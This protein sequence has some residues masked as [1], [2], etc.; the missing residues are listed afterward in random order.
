MGI[1]R[2]LGFPALN[3]GELT[4]SGYIYPKFAKIKNN[5]EDEIR[6][7]L[8]ARLM[9]ISFTYKMIT[10]S[11]AVTAGNLGGSGGI[12]SSPLGG[13]ALGL[14]GGA[15][16]SSLN[17]GGIGQGFAYL[18]YH[19]CEGEMRRNIPIVLTEKM[20]TDLKVTLPN[21]VVSVLAVTKK[22]I[23]FTDEQI[24]RLSDNPG[25]NSIHG[26]DGLTYDDGQFFGRS[27]T[28]F[29]DVGG[30]AFTDNDNLFDGILFDDRLLR[31]RADNNQTSN[32]GFI[33]TS[34]RDAS[35]K[36]IKLNVGNI[37]QSKI[38]AGDTVY[39]TAQLIK[40]RIE[41]VCIKHQATLVET[42]SPLGLSGS[43]ILNT[44]NILQSWSSHISKFKVPKSV[45]INVEK[46]STYRVPLNISDDDTDKYDLVEGWRIASSS[47][48]R[49]KVIFAADRR[50]ILKLTL[51][52]GGAIF[53]TEV[54]L[55]RS[56]IRD[57]EWFDQFL[58]DNSLDELI[59]STD[60][61]K[62]KLER[63][64]SHGA[65]FDMSA[66]VNQV[67][68]DKHKIPYWRPFALA[69]QNVSPFKADDPTSG[70]GITNLD[71]LNDPYNTGHAVADS[72]KYDLSSVKFQFVIKNSNIASTDF[73]NIGAWGVQ[74]CGDLEGG[75]GFYDPSDFLNRTENRL[76]ITGPPTT[77]GNIVSI[78][79]IDTPFYL[80]KFKRKTRIYVENFTVGISPRSRGG[81][82]VYVYTLPLT[83]SSLSADISPFA[84]EAVLTFNDFDKAALAMHHFQ[85]GY[86]DLEQINTETNVD[87]K[88]PETFDY[89]NSLYVGDNR[90]IGDEPGYS[91]GR[92]IT[93]EATLSKLEQLPKDF[94]IT[95]DFFNSIISE[96][97]FSYIRTD[98]T[99]LVRSISLDYSL[100]FFNPDDI[101][102]IRHAFEFVSDGRVVDN[103]RFEI[104]R[105]LHT[106]K[107]DAA[108]YQGGQINMYG[109]LLREWINKKGNISLNSLTGLRV[110]SVTNENFD[111]V[112]TESDAFS[113]VIDG[114]RRL[115]V[116]YEDEERENISAL[117][118]FDFGSTWYRFRDVLR[119]TKD[120]I[121][122]KPIA[123][124]DKIKDEVDLFYTLNETFL[125][126]ILIPTNAFDLVDLDKTYDK[127]EEFNGK[128]P[129]NHGI[130]Q[131]SQQGQQLRLNRSSFVHG[132]ASDEFYTMQRDITIER[133]KNKLESRFDISGREE[134]L[135]AYF[136]DFSYSLYI[137][138]EGVIYLYFVNGNKMSIKSGYSNETFRY[139]VKDVPLHVNF[140][141]EQGVDIE[142][143]LTLFNPEDDLTYIVYGFDGKLFYRKFDQKIFSAQEG[144]AMQSL[145]SD[146][147]AKEKIL[148]LPIFIVGNLGSE[149]VTAINSKNPNLLFDFPYTDQGADNF[150]DSKEVNTG[151]TPAGYISAN[152]LARLFYADSDDQIRGISLHPKSVLDV[153]LVPRQ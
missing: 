56:R 119:L 82:N 39:I 42:S 99:K 49:L 109:S 50:G 1:C 14:L 30:N 103:R 64:G 125:M 12:Y 148:G 138:N 28:E 102:P 126:H 110:T 106:D 13:G 80:G 29:V 11:K 54:I 19:V 55:I 105:D 124:S 128:S 81:S 3:F 132:N 87:V 46:D 131:F 91:H 62:G 31:Y 134:N 17:L 93:T 147:S 52:Y 58:I 63:G 59:P 86:V 47:D 89:T 69:L 38:K 121:A 115:I 83:L 151:I 122:T 139:I 25:R 123:I 101:Y 107:I 75:A 24:N 114:G 66:H 145:F 10:A 43:D 20:V 22:P 153:Q 135:D 113:V 97:D 78:W 37:V 45:N 77:G 9:K 136:E 142:R 150:D 98:P 140:K 120:E 108:Y 71:L 68:L 130:S 23:V 57:Q 104:Y 44:G 118:S 141:E 36:I 72:E 48:F 21:H 152:G 74:N 129:N 2:P 65:L 70:V 73:Q 67:L 111:S 100:P 127:V 96:T 117:V 94:Y 16:I 143:I 4:P 95:E 92:P 35:S 61:Q 33:N 149:L 26:I 60:K 18:T 53:N 7:Q 88:I 34:Q 15:I 137:D 41:R 112:K 8:P 116:F 133:A 51:G 27:I 5:G 79:M 32:H 144:P 6:K 76:S 146:F 90:I 84:H 40:K 85:E